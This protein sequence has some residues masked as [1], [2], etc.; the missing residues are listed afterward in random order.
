MINTRMGFFTFRNDRI[1]NLSFG[2]L[3]LLFILKDSAIRETKLDYYL[4]MSKLDLRFGFNLIKLLIRYL[5][6]HLVLPSY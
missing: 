2:K 3:L 4:L 5:F 1:H 6:R